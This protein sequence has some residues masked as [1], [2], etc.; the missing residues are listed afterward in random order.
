M[1]SNRY[2]KKRQKID[3]STIQQILSRFPMITLLNHIAFCNILDLCKNY[4]L[5]ETFY[6]LLLQA[7]R[8]L[9]W[10]KE[11]QIIDNRRDT[12]HID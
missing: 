6:I 2:V 8:H 7:E 4:N 5:V 12:K 3:G 9:A 10:V 11:G 1:L